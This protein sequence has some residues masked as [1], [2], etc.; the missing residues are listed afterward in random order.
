MTNAETVINI[1]F[2]VRQEPP[3]SPSHNDIRPQW[4]DQNYY[5]YA[6]KSLWSSIIYV[7]KKV[8]AEVAGDG[9]AKQLIS[10]KVAPAF[11]VKARGAKNTRIW[12]KCQRKC[13]VFNTF[14]LKLFQETLKTPKQQK[15]LELL[16]RAKV[17]NQIFSRQ[18]GLNTPE[19]Q[20][21]ITF[22]FNK[23]RILHHSSFILAQWKCERFGEAYWWV[24]GLQ[25]LGTGALLLIYS[26]YYS[27][28]A[29]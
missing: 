10:L 6:D 29:S 7:A 23:T 15:F 9:A 4:N 5:K 11:E 21:L 22:S 18:S 26:L 16:R 12:S 25:D 19:W 3:P 8:D 20:I 24:T 27:G 28:A 13:V 1:F 17:K 2:Y 14:L